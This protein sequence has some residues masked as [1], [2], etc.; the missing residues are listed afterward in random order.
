MTDTHAR[1]VL[2]WLISDAVRCDPAYRNRTTGG[3][4]QGE[5]GRFASRGVKRLRWTTTLR[6][7]ALDVLR[8]MAESQGIS[9]NEVVE[10]LLLNA[11]PSQQQL[12]E[13]RDHID[14][15]IQSI[16]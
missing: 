2:G 13:L 9:R 15:I 11:S 5:G 16:T 10:A 14:A 8:E 4:V 3:G 7:E 12:I 6:P 1:P